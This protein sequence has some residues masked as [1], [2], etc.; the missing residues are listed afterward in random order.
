M[1]KPSDKGG[2]LVIMDKS[3]YELMVFT[4]LN[5]REWY[6]KVSETHLKLT[7]RRYQ[8]LIG[9]AYYDGLITKSAWEFL[10]VTCPRTPTLYTLPKIHKNSSNPPGRLYPAMAP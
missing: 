9:S 2:N 1:I 5:N 7:I 6:R 10:N 8:D 3:H 4:L